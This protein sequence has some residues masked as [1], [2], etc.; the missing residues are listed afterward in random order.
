[1]LSLKSVVVLTCACSI[2]MTG[3]EPETGS[4]D[5]KILPTTYPE[6]S[7]SVNRLE[8]NPIIRPDMLRGKLGASISGPSLIRVPDWVKNPLGKYYLYFAH[9]H[10]SFIRMAYA[11]ELDGPWSVYPEGVLGMENPKCRSLEEIGLEQPMHIASPDVHVDENLQKIR[12]YFHCNTLNPEH[13]LTEK[14]DLQNSF[15]SVSSDGLD[16]QAQDE[17]IARSHLRVFQKGELFF[18]I[19]GSRHLYHS[20][21]A[22]SRF[23]QGKRILP[24]NARH[25]ATHVRESSLFVFYSLKGDHPEQIV[26]STVRMTDDWRSW[27]ASSPVSVIKPE[28]KWEGV[29]VP[30]KV[31]KGGMAK[32]RYQELRDPAIFVEDDKTYL[33]YSVAGESGIA[34]AELAWNE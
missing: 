28:E 29:D 18:G 10:G 14:K 12:M 23:T 11:N 32:N 19:T 26:V 13:E 1:M 15:L 17:I 2:L 7:I 8:N 3:C 20:E 21:S 25:V 16:F 30:L 6:S 22:T 24:R 34:I 5:H 27:S 4:P 9:H 33:L 31:S